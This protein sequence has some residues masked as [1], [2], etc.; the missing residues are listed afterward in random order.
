MVR[1]KSD[2]ELK[3]WLKEVAIAREAPTIDP[4]EVRSDS[5]PV[6]IHASH[7][8]R[9]RT[10]HTYLEFV[11]ALSAVS[12]QAKEVL[13]KVA[14][15]KDSDM[16]IADILA[17]DYAGEA[18]FCGI[19]VG[20]IVVP[21]LSMHRHIDD[22]IEHPARSL[23]LYTRR[24]DYSAFQPGAVIDPPAPVDSTTR[25]K[26]LNIEIGVYVVTQAE[27]ARLLCS[28]HWTHRERIP[29]SSTIRPS[30]GSR[31]NGIASGRTL[32]SARK[33]IVDT[34]VNPDRLES[35]L[36]FR[37][38]APVEGAGDIIATD[39]TTVNFTWAF[40]Y[41]AHELAHFRGI[42]VPQKW[43]TPV[44]VTTMLKRLTKAKNEGYLLAAREPSY[45]KES[46]GKTH[47]YAARLGDVVAVNPKGDTAKTTKGGS[48]ARK[49]AS[50]K[51]TSTSAVDT[52]RPRPGTLP[53]GVSM[54]GKRPASTALP[55]PDFPPRSS[56]S[57]RIPTE[58]RRDGHGHRSSD[59]DEGDWTD[60]DSDDGTGSDSDD[61]GEGYDFSRVLEKEKIITSGV[62]GEGVGY[63][64]DTLIASGVHGLSSIATGERPGPLLGCAPSQHL[65]DP[66]M[67]GGEMCVDAE[68]EQ[69]LAKTLS[70]EV[71]G[72]AHGGGAGDID[73]EHGGV[74]NYEIFVTDHREPLP[75]PQESIVDHERIVTTPPSAAATMQP[76][77]P[78]EMSPPHPQ[79]TND[80]NATPSPAQQQQD[81]LPRPT[82]EP[83]HAPMPR[84]DF[85]KTFQARLEPGRHLYHRSKVERNAAREQVE[86]ALRIAA[87][88]VETMRPC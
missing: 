53:S 49:K 12:P 58:A 3:A 6:F 64:E 15:K 26:D 71:N 69:A 77:A 59:D 46:M 55:M 82:T 27:F 78:L 56:K 80:E 79:G 68:F 28:P 36:L 40:E 11:S 16:V 41:G 8:L 2:D 50:K 67:Y 24:E 52:P 47:I 18:D 88:V 1:K 14:E 43:K 81:P 5:S 13:R 84:F 30:S 75:L 76:P 61:D 20:K 70:D 62:V 65:D 23:S 29:S 72:L 44:V 19:C 45:G 10:R 39:P 85:V 4:N 42:D 32:R 37:T 51:S 38:R 63:E 25:E 9:S 17:A 74:S 73:M 34:A 87:S 48:G 66:P 7:S 21:L 33:C 35:V 22:S 86:R 54:L 57:I 60:E 83:E 31:T